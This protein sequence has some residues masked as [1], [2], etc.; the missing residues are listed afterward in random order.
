M[1]HVLIGSEEVEGEESEGYFSVS[2]EN[3]NEVLKF[4][5]GASWLHGTS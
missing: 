4:G 5:L 1:K 3:K 2:H